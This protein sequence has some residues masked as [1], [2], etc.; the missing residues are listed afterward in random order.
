MVGVHVEIDVDASAPQQAPANRG[1]A[2]RLVATGAHA[3]VDLLHLLRGRA[4]IPGAVSAGASQ[5]SPQSR[6][7]NQPLELASQGDRV[8]EREQ[9]SALPVAR[10]LL[11]QRQM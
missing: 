9:Q 6:L 7:A 3:S 5:L 10:E 2:A 11:I 8:A 1:V 4:P